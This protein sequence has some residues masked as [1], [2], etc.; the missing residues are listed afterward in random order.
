MYVEYNSLAEAVYICL[1][2]KRHL[3]ACQLNPSKTKCTTY[4]ILYGIPF[5]YNALKRY[6]ITI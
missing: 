4:E 5:I 6:Y 3:H 1:D 2:I